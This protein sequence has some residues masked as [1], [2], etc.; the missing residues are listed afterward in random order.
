MWKTCS[1]QWQPHSDGS[2]P[3]P[4]PQA[5]M[6]TLPSASAVKRFDP[7]LQV[8]SC[9]LEKS[10]YCEFIRHDIG[11]LKDLNSSVPKPYE[12]GNMPYQRNCTVVS[13]IHTL[14]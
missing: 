1:V 9:H 10:K 8:T 13:F 3:S 12:N 7:G 14:Y 6:Q 4:A 5:S 2:G 11:S